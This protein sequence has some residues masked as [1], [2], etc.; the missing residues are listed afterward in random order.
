MIATQ[1]KVFKSTSTVSV[2]DW[3]NDRK[4]LVENDRVILEVARTDDKC[5]QCPTCLSRAD[6][7]EEFLQGGSYVWKWE[8]FDDGKWISIA[9]PKKTNPIKFLADAVGLAI[10]GVAPSESQPQRRSGSTRLTREH[11]KSRV[12][13]NYWENARKVLVEPDRVLLQITLTCNHCQ[14]CSSRVS[15]IDA[16]VRSKPD[17]MYRWEYVDGFGDRRWISLPRSNGQDPLDLLRKTLGIRLS[18]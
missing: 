14:T 8:M 9:S 15:Q 13:V 5:H 10:N 3:T 2:A 18:E 7:I 6:K 17:V 12:Y 16:M 11:Y 1:R 4:L